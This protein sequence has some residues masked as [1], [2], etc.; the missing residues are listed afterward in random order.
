[1]ER[2]CTEGSL[3]S[4]SLKYEREKG[5]SDKDNLWQRTIYDRDEERKESMFGGT[6]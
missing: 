4:D 1:M 6:I 3:E 5:L 2:Q